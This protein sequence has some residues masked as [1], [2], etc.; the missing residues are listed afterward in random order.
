MK[1]DGEIQRSNV[2]QQTYSEEYAGYQ[3]VSN[4]TFDK[5]GNYNISCTVHA[6]ETLTAIEKAPFVCAQHATS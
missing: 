3:R 4:T 1:N 6:Q 5:G 2:Y